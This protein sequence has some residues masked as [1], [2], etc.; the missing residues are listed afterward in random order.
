MRRLKYLQ[1]VRVGKAKD[2]SFL[3]ALEAKYS[4]AGNG[5]PEKRKGS[6]VRQMD[7]AGQ[8]RLCFG[9]QARVNFWCRRVV[10]DAEPSE[11]DFASARS[12][13]SGSKGKLKSPR[14]Q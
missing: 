3:D 10:Q 8:S 12:R 7:S 4:K 9:G 1:R 14:R 2:T 13:L 11:A 6:K 5:K